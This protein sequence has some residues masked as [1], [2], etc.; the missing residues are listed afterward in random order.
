[1]LFIRRKLFV[2]RESLLMVVLSKNQTTHSLFSKDMFK[3]I[4]IF[5]HNNKIRKVLEQSNVL[6]YLLFLKGK[7]LFLCLVACLQ[8]SCSF[9]KMLYKSRF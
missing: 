8:M 7:V 5:K 1:M 4:E 6:K 9:I 2:L 3:E